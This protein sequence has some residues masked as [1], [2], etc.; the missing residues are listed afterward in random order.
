MRLS[1]DGTPLTP[2]GITRSGR[3]VQLS[4]LLMS[5]PCM[6]VLKS[7]SGSKPKLSSSSSSS[8]GAAANGFILHDSSNQLNDSVRTPSEQ[9]LMES[10]MKSL[11]LN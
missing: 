4:V 6:L 7:K 2:L 1:V 11:C 3:R 8:G 9:L 5:A 10:V